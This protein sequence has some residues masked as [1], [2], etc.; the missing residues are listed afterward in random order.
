[1]R[2][3]TNAHTPSS[4]SAVKQRMALIPKI[5]QLI[6]GHVDL[7]Q[8]PGGYVIM[9]M[10]MKNAARGRYSGNNFEVIAESVKYEIMESFS[11]L[12]IDVKKAADYITIGVDVVDT[13]CNLVTAELVVT[14]NAKNNCVDYVTGKSYPTSDQANSLIY[15]HDLDS[16]FQMLN[17]H[18]VVV[19]GCHDL[20]MFMKRSIANIKR[21]SGNT[22]KAIVTEDFFKKVTDFKP[23]VVLH[24]PH[25]T[26]LVS[27]WQAKWSGMMEMLPYVKTYSSGINYNEIDRDPSTWSS[28]DNLLRSTMKG[29]VKNVLC[30]TE[31]CHFINI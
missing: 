12:L 15:C 20:T 6:P 16:H 25:Y 26:V 30:D 5:A 10:D 24:H 2:L 1:M 8:T 31:D 4:W 23:E 28:L 9:T 19:L 22:Y 17:G 21:G 18:K 27:T 13:S 14:Y 11:D 29:N 7:I 3:I